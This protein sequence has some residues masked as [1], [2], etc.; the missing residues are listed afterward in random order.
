M[1]KDDKSD[2]AAHVHWS[3]MALSPD[4]KITFF[5]DM[6]KIWASKETGYRMWIISVCQIFCQYTKSLVNTFVPSESSEIICETFPNYLSCPFW[7]PGWPGCV[8]K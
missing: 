1:T 3:L 7:W 6:N 2:W 5:T 8:E 4:K